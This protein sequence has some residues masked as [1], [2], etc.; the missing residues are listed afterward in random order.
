M[1][2]QPVIAVMPAEAQRRCVDLELFAGFVHAVAPCVIEQRPPDF[3][4]LGC[5]V[6]CAADLDQRPGG[7]GLTVRG[8]NIN[9]A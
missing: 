5:P 2:P 1:F 7:N 6:A 4:R 3:M 9:R 8:H